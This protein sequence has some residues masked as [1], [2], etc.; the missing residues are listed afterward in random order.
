MTKHRGGLGYNFAPQ[1]KY[2]EPFKKLLK[3]KTHWFDLIKDFNFNPLPSQLSFK[4]DIFRQFG[5]IRPRSV[6]DT[7]YAIPETYDKYYTFDRNYIHEMGSNTF[8]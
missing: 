4:A 1:P 3:S 5:A 6:G 2:I 8:I 7:K